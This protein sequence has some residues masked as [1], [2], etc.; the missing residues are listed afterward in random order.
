MRE[1]FDEVAGKSQLD[2]QE[3]VR[4]STRGPRPK[5]FYANAG[6][7]ETADGF[8]ITLDDKNVRTPSK[9]QLVAPNRVLAEAIA[10]EWQ[11]QAELIDPTSMPLTRLANS[12]IDGVA[13]RVDAV[14]DDIADLLPERFAVL[15]RQLSR[16][17][18]GA[19]SRALGS[20][21][22]LGRRDAERAFHPGRRHRACAPA[23]GGDRSRARGVAARCVVGRGAA[24][25]DLDHRLGA[26]GAGAARAASSMP[27]R[28]GPRRMSTRTGTSQQWGV[29]EEV[30]A[31]RAARLVDFQA[32]VAALEALAAG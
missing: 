3:A 21:A 24:C 14:T 25:R 31:R 9:Q 15:S 4:R 30:A 6:F 20:G 12:V 32:A 1:L 23:R 5:R 18:G 29:D 27:I 16:R 7:A 13:E 11:A 19:R 10:A 2:P 8:A 17:A 22:V 28:S 26:A